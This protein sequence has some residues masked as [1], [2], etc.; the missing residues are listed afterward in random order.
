MADN[1]IQKLSGD[2][3]DKANDREEH[4]LNDNFASFDRSAK[5]SSEN[6]FN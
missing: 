4:Q 2:S 6:F 5:N 3:K 1:G